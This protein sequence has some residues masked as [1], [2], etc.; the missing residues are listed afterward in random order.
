MSFIACCGNW[1]L[2]VT[3]LVYILF[4]LNIRFHTCT[5]KYD[6]YILVSTYLFRKHCHFL[7]WGG[8]L[9][10][11]SSVFS[12][13]FTFHVYVMFKHFIVK[14]H[15]PSLGG[16]L[17][18]CTCRGFVVAFM[19]HRLEWFCFLLKPILLRH[20]Q[21]WFYNLVTDQWRFEKGSV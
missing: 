21:T 10:C 17:Q 13:D 11:Q 3:I 8:G 15:S 6:T 2:K 18:R 1:K 16:A 4:H 14:C 7:R 5:Y 20:F 19:N 9:T 12:L